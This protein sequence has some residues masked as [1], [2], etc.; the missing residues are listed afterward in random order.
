MTISNCITD[1]S[2]LVFILPYQLFS[3]TSWMRP[4]VCGIHM[5][6]DHQR[7]TE[8]PAVG[9]KSCT[10]SQNSTQLRT[11]F[12][13]WK[14]QTHSCVGVTAHSDQ[15][16]HVTQTSTTSATFWWVTV[17]SSCWFLSS[18]GFVPGFKEYNPIF[19]VTWDETTFENN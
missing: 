17:E 4:P 1:I 5:S 8:Y 16:C 11:A 14:E 13:Q 6:S 2:E 7:M 19:S 9:P 15:Q 18:V 3:R 10:C 12:P